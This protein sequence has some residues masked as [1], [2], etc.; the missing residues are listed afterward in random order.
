MVASPEE[1]G[2]EKDCAGKDQQ[3]I[4]KADP[5]S[6]HK[7]KYRN[8]QRVIKIWS[9]APDGCFMSR[10]TDRLTVGRKMRLRLSEVRSK[11]EANQR[12]FE[13][14]A[15]LQRVKQNSGR[16]E[17]QDSNNSDGFVIQKKLNV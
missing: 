15:E 4:Q 12:A 2:P 9:Q 6:R 7:N 11:S 10:Q 1:L 8:C 5:S 17:V 14:Q 3:H 16:S 13:N